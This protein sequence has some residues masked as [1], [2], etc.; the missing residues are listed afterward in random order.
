MT[1]VG[2]KNHET[3]P[4]RMRLNIV[5]FNSPKKHADDDAGGEKFVE[6]LATRKN[7]DDE[8]R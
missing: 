2:G 8:S 5:L 1:T 4:S 7:L 3:L 6:Q